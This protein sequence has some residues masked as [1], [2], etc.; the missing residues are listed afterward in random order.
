LGSEDA[1][2]MA[3]MGVTTPLAAAMVGYLKKQQDKQEMELAAQAELLELAQEAIIVRDMHGRVT[4]W[5]HGAEDLYQWS[6]GDAVGRD[7]D[8]MLETTYPIAAGAVRA[9]ILAQGHWAGEIR[10]SRKGGD[11]LVLETHQALQL[12]LDGRPHRILVISRDITA[13]RAAE[14]AAREADQRFRALAEGSFEGIAIFEQGT[15]MLVNE[16]LA[17]LF[18]AEPYEFIG[19][20]GD[21]LVVELQ[22]EMIRARIHGAESVP[23]EVVALRPDGSTFAAEV[24]FRDAVQDGTPVRFMAIRDITERKEA[25]RL[26]NEIL[27]MVSHDL[28]NPLAAIRM[29]LDVALAGKAHDGGP[30]PMVLETARRSC[31][32]LIRLTTDLMDRQRIAEG[33]FALD[34]GACQADDIVEQAVAEVRP[35]ADPRGI[36]V[37][38]DCDP[39]ALR[40]DRERLVQVILNLLH[41]AIKFSP[42]GATVTLKGKADPLEVRFEVED[43][44]RGIPAEKREAVFERFQVVQAEDAKQFGGF[45][46]GLPIC[47]AVVER[48]GGRIWAER[49]EPEGS[50]FVIALPAGEV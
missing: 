20:Q 34:I 10:Q 29:S 28:R 23:V 35:I 39:F 8:D 24:R 31:D 16:A 11:V 43:R 36:S 32:R 14:T 17:R 47:R 44:G 49:A 40:G 48:H 5:N 30:P 50:R 3:V 45:G 1:F 22:R 37:D 12:G 33:I 9:A 7:L 21:D 6:A 4:Y 25:E 19:L 46:L 15:I 18:R 38:V 26:K 13:R 42:D 27:G 2:R 41:N